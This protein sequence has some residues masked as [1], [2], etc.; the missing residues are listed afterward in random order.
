MD[1][2]STGRCF[3]LRMVSTGVNKWRVIVVAKREWRDGE[4]RDGIRKVRN[5]RGSKAAGKDVY[6][7]KVPYRE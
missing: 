3:L 7:F 1:A 2:I 4:M 6:S 5:A